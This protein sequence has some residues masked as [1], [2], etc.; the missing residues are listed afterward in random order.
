MYPYITNK[1]QAYFSHAKSSSY[2]TIIETEKHCLNASINQ[3]QKSEL[4]VTP[5]IFSQPC[6]CVCSYA[7][8]QRCFWD[9]KESGEQSP[10]SVQ[11]PQACPTSTSESLL[12]ITLIVLT[13]KSQEN[14]FQRITYSNITYHILLSNTCIKKIVHFRQ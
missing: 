3:A 13:C 6:V 5:A 9:E 4:P 7:E 11:S 10:T 2:F 8:V 14:R 12:L 1:S